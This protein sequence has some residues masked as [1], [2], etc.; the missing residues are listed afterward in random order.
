VYGK[1]SPWEIQAQGFYSH[2]HS[3]QVFDVAVHRFYN[4]E[5]NFGASVGE[6]YWAIQQP[7]AQ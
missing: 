2:D 3:K 7:M 4:V 1:G 6:G 5:M